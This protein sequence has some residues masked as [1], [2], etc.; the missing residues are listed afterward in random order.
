MVRRSLTVLPVM[1]LAATFLSSAVSANDLPLFKTAQ[2]RPAPPSPQQ[3]AQPQ[4]QQ[5]PQP[6]PPL[7]VRTEIL[8][9]E[10]WVVTCREF[11]APKKRDCAALLQVNQANNNQTIFTW[12]FGLDATN[13]PIAV[14]QTPTG[15][16]IGPGVELRLEKAQPRKVPYTACDNGRCTA[17]MTVDS[18]LVRDMM[19]AANAEIVIQAVNGSKLQF[20][21]PLKGFDKAYP[22]LR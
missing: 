19:A 11:L 15:V 6:P 10:N 4:S 5:T 14:L 21:I 7:P 1:L 18:N 8:N 12:T 3:P 2:N 13:H 20:N 16:M 17:T 9:F 22:A